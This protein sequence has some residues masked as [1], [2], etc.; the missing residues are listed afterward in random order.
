[1]PISRGST[2]SLSL[3]LSNLYCSAP[4]ESGLRATLRERWGRISPAGCTLKRRAAEGVEDVA[5]Y[6]AVTGRLRDGDDAM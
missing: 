3:Y 5:I 4:L 2:P 6:S 1:M